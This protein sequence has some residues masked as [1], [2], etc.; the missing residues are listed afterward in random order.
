MGA[1]CLKRGDAAGF[2]SEEQGTARRPVT[3]QR[4]ELDR[5]GQ[6]GERSAAALL[7]G[8]NHVRAQ[9]VMLGVVDHGATGDD[10][11]DAR[12]AQFTGLF[13]HPV[14]PALFE[15]R[16]AQPQVGHRLTFTQAFGHIENDVTPPDIVGH[17]EPF[18]GGII[19]QLDRIA[20][21]QPHD[22][23]EI[24]RGRPVNPQRA[25]GEH[26]LDKEARG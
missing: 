22:R 18:A 5:F 4:G 20:G 24:M 15:R 1:H 26:G 9:P 8:L 17:A 2:V 19:K 12:H 7:G 6:F 16:R 13:D 3:Q 21:L 14:D 10:R 23:D 11:D 25:G